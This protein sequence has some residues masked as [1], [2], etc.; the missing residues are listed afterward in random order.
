M[1]DDYY[2]SLCANPGQYDKVIDLIVEKNPAAKSPRTGFPDAES[3]AV[4]CVHTVI[5]GVVY[6]DKADYSTGMAF[7]MGVER[8]EGRKARLAFEP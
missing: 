6:G 8:S 1:R 5:R 4:E 7:A 3:F 2:R